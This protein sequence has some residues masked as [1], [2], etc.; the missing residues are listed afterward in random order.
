MSRINDELKNKIDQNSYEIMNWKEL[1]KEMWEQFQIDNSSGNIILAI[2]YFIVGFGVFGTVLMMT[3]ERRREFGIM[4]AVGMKRDK[5]SLMVAL[6]LLYII[7]MGL[8]VGMAGS[9]P[10]LAYYHFNP[11][12]LTGSAAEIYSSMG[13]EPVIPVLWQ[14]FYIFNQGLVVFVIVLFVILYPLWNI[15]KLDVPRAIRS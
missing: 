6:E 15:R 12:R 1:M 13:M 4:A 7:S 3:N 9:I 2:L 10:I 11:I 14:S 5:L 8:I